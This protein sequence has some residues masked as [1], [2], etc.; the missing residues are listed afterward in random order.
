MFINLS[1]SSYATKKA[2][3]EAKQAL[4]VSLSTVSGDDVLKTYI[5]SQG[6]SEVGRIDIPKDYMLSD[7]STGTVTA[8]DLADGGKLFGRSDFEVGDTYIEFDVNVNGGGEGT[9]KKVFL[10]AKSL[11]GGGGSAITSSNGVLTDGTYEWYNKEEI[12]NQRKEYLFNDTANSIISQFFD[13]QI[14]TKQENLEY[15]GDTINGSVSNVYYANLYSSSK[16]FGDAYAEKG[17]SCSIGGKGINFYHLVTGYKDGN[18]VQDEHFIISDKPI[19][20]TQG[21]VSIQGKS[22]KRYKIYLGNAYPINTNVVYPLGESD[23]TITFSLE[24]DYVYPKYYFT[25]GTSV[26][27]LSEVS[28]GYV[29]FG[30]II[31][32]GEP[33]GWGVFDYLNNQTKEKIVYYGPK[34]ESEWYTKEYIDNLPTGGASLSEENGIITDGTINWYSKDY[35]DEINYKND[36]IP[37]NEIW[38]K[39][40]DGQ[41]IDVPTNGYNVN[42]VSNTYENGIGR[43]KFD[44]V[45]TSIADDFFNSPAVFDYKL[46]SVKFPDEINTIGNNFLRR[47]GYLESVKLPYKLNTVGK[48]F[49]ESCRNIITINLPDNITTV[50]DCFLYNC[51]KLTIVTLPDNLTTAGS[52]LL[53]D[54]TNLTT[55]N[56]PNNLNEIKSNSFLGCTSLSNI[57]LPD[58]LKIIG[59]YFLR[60]CTSLSNLRLPDKIEKFAKNGFI[61]NNTQSGVLYYPVSKK[62]DP[63]YQSIIA[64]IPATWTAEPYGPDSGGSTITETDGIL[65]D[66]TYEW[67]DKSKC[68]LEI[69]ESIEGIQEYLEGEYVAK[70][71]FSETGG[72][73][74]IDGVGSGG[75]EIIHATINNSRQV[76]DV[77]E[78]NSEGY[79][80][81]GY[82]S[83]E[84]DDILIAPLN[85]A[86]SAPV[87]Y[88]YA[89]PNGVEFSGKKFYLKSEFNNGKTISMDEWY[90][91][92]TEETSGMYFGIDKTP[93]LANMY[94]AYDAVKGVAK[95]KYS[96]TDNTVPMTTA[97]GQ[98]E[99][100][101]KEAIDNKIGNIEEL[102]SKI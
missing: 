63:V 71:D 52:E 32:D 58:N 48:Y 84:S 78:A 5:L 20:N 75:T 98:I 45:L 100:Y 101:N 97:G 55:V 82:Y 21:A 94:V 86:Y 67:Y 47:C 18:Y 70:Y 37:N 79:F 89:F 22:G 35:I 60:G 65:T 13:N 54:C 53:R 92:G 68:D 33:V 3:E 87:R 73:V 24:W 42:F 19:N 76:N 7:A 25:T 38:Y 1:M 17:F 43:V 72:V 91:F 90:E 61:A 39:T 15:N 8:E 77:F 28:P 23:G 11:G 16:K 50:G 2:L 44:G 80:I 46:I 14:N 66:G 56:F 74:T 41:I 30:I 26:K 99:V 9:V 12:E 34:K 81:T 102:L 83:N 27:H 10:N 64:A 69:A 51:T 6:G 85:D 36:I 4:E 40:D 96:L 29:H 93:S 88:Y 62:D 31:F 49:L 59:S 95:F 57:K